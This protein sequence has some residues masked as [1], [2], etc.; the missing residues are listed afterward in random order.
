MTIGRSNALNATHSAN[1]GLTACSELA[2]N[3]T[4]ESDVKIGVVKD[5]EPK[6]AIVK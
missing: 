1:A 5:D 6:F 4:G 2:R 3:D